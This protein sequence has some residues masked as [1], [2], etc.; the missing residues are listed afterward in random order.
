[1]NIGRT[2][3]PIPHRQNGRVGPNRSLKSVMP[4]S[5]ELVNLDIYH[6]LTAYKNPMEDYL[7]FPQ[8][9]LTPGW[10]RTPKCRCLSLQWF[11]L[12]AVD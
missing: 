12:Q 10:D 3:A 2:T 8:S 4:V 6:Q 7:R 5:P 11:D 9:P 1:M